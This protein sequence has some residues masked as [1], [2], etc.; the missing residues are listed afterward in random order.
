MHL[1]V[2][3][4]AISQ[5][6]QL[7]SVA[8]LRDS[9]TPRICDSGIRDSPICDSP[10]A[11]LGYVILLGLGIRDSPRVKA[12]ARDIPRESFAAPTVRCSSTAGTRG[13]GFKLLSVFY[14]SR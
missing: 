7:T 5:I 14:P 6:H 8:V 4:Y 1:D 9:H 12:R 10:R 3:Q 13:P 11:S 2:K